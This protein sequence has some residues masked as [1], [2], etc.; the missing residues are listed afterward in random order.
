M[1]K[2]NKIISGKREKESW[3]REI[4]ERREEWTEG[5]REGGREGGTDGGREG[6]REGEEE[7]T[8]Q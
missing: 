4:E 8:L 5:E 7:I 3:C 6:K 1:V 2:G